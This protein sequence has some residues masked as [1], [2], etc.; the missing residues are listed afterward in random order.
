MSVIDDYL[1]SVPV[2][3]RK[4][5]ERVRKIVAS[6]VPGTEDAISYGMPTLKYKGMNLIHFAAFKNHMS[7][8]PTSQPAEELADKLK[9]YRTSKGTLQ[10]TEKNPVPENLIKE[11]VTIRLHKIK[12]T[13][14]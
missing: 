2:A 4:E 9:E 13:P 14:K 1:K 11:I 7:I 5:L 12:E 8:F 10:F 3:Q 6:F